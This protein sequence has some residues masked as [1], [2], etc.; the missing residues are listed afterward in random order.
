MRLFL[1]EEVLNREAKRGLGNASKSRT[2]AN[3]APVRQTLGPSSIESYASAIVDLWKMQHARGENPIAPSQRDHLLK[4]MLKK[5][6]MDEAV[7][8]RSQYVDRGIGTLL[9]GYSKQ[10]LVTCVR[11]C[12]AAEALEEK[13]GRK[14]KLSA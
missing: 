2:D 3:G 7:R 12:W 5:R 1:E 11:S 10:E 6:R 4:G 14:K 13:L 9:D 8:K